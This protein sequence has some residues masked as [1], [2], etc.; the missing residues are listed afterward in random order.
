MWGKEKN[1]NEKKT[2]VFVVWMYC[3]Y[4]SLQ[5][6]HE[7][8]PYW[9]ND[10]E[11]LE[12]RWWS[13]THSE[14]LEDGPRKDQVTFLLLFFTHPF[15]FPSPPSP[16]PPSFLFFSPLLSLLKHAYRSGE[17]DPTFMISHRAT[18]ASGPQ[19]YKQFNERTDGVIKVFL[20][21]AN[22]SPAQ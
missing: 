3:Y 8:L 18:L 21:T 22:S 16:S 15:F 20:R 10:G 7:S 4:W 19:L 13:V 2:N 14:V 12:G 17:L 11:R 9:S 1:E 6:V 5:W